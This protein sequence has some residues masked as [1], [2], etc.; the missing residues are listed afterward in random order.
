MTTTKADRPEPTTVRRILEIRREF[1]IIEPL[2]FSKLTMKSADDYLAEIIRRTGKKELTADRNT[3]RA[4]SV[5]LARNM[6][7]LVT[8]RQLT[9]IRAI[10]NAHRVDQEKTCVAFFGEPIKPEELSRRAASRFM[11]YLKIAELKATEHQATA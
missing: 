5:N 11:D 2:D 1:A 10:C 3:K 7:E 6:G 4:A 9:A 8:P